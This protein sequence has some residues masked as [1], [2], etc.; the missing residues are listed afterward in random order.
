VHLSNR[1]TNDTCKMNPTQNEFMRCTAISSLFEQTISAFIY[2]NPKWNPS[3][4]AFDVILDT[5]N[6]Y[7]YYT[8]YIFPRSIILNACRGPTIQYPIAKFFDTSITYNEAC[9]SRSILSLINMIRDFA[10]LR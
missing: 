6:P 3:I 1:K 5:S 4:G 7:E 2:R 9:S 10:F 8:I